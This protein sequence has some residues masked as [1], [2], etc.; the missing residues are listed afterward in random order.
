MEHQNFVP[1]SGKT[2]CMGCMQFYNAE[3]DVCPFCGYQKDTPVKAPWHIKPGTLLVGRYV[4]GRVVGYG[5]FGVTYIAWDTMLKRRIAIKEYLPSEFATRMADE[6]EIMLLDGEKQLS[7]YQKGLDRFLQEGK[8]L[9]QVGDISGIVHMYNCFQANGT[10]YITMEFL[11]GRTLEEYLAEKGHLTEQETLDLMMPVLEA[12]QSVHE[13]G[14]IHRDI[15]P[16]NIFLTADNEGHLHAKLIDFGASRFATTS[17]SK[18]LTVLIRPGYSPEEQYRSN[19]QQ[20]TFTDVYAVAACMYRMVTGQQPPDALER[21]S[22]IEAKKPDLLQEPGRLNPDLSSNFETALLNALNVRVEDRTA[23]ISDFQEELVSFEPVKRRGDSIRRID[24]LRWPLWA[25]IGVPVAGAAALA[26]LVL[27]AVWVFSSPSSSYALPEGMTRVPDFITAS[28][29]EAQGWADESHLLLTS[30]GAE[31]SPNMTADLVLSQD[32]MAGTVVRENTNISVIISCSQETYQMPD[33]RGMAQE[34]ALAALT[35]MGLAVDTQEGS[36]DGLAA[37]AVAGQSTEPGAEIHTGDAVTLTLSAGSGRAG[38]VPKLEGLSYEE[39]LAAAESA[40]VNLVVKARPFTDAYQDGQVMQQ[41]PGAGGSVSA[42]QTVEIQV[43]QQPR[44]FAMPNLLF[45]SQDEALHLL[46]NIGLSADVQEETSDAVMSGLVLSQSTAAGQQVTPGGRVSLSVSKGGTPVNMPDVVGKT[47]DE[48]RQALSTCRLALNVEY[49]Y[50]AGKAEGTVL[51]QDPVS[52]AP[53]ARGSTVS[54]VVCSK[55]GLV[56]VSDVMGKSSADAKTML[57]GQKLKVQLNEVYS[58][59]AAGTVIAQLPNAGSMQ[60][61]GTVIVLTVSKGKQ[62]APTPAPTPTPAPDPTP[63][64]EPD[65]TPTPTP[66][67]EPAPTWSDWMTSLP[68]G[69]TQ[70]SYYIETKTQYSYRTRET[71]TSESSSMPGWTQVSASTHWG[72]YGAWSDWQDGAVYASDSRQVETRVVYGYYYFQCYNCG[73]RMWGWDMTCPKWAGGCGVGYIDRGSW[74]QMW[75]T[76]SWTD[77]NCQEYG[78]TGKYITY[79]FSD[80]RWFQWGNGDGG[81]KTQY[82]YRDRTQVTVYT[83]ERWTSWTGY[84]DTYRAAD[85]NTQVR[86]RTL[87]RYKK[88]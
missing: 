35:C 3:F 13:K 73:A 85:T 69:V 21:R 6:Q 16:D 56:A 19:G 23:S 88:R 59:S 64:P 62:P 10:A 32:T 44:S 38:T 78:G 14:I 20:G 81:P 52:G 84:S 9:A 50:D 45:K 29:D 68:A 83:Y 34:E 8:R 37:G 57:E 70:S 22:R 75:S 67:P 2:Q 66:T 39:A 36:Y 17:H 79:A 7:Q 42:G 80:G 54:I 86:T 49:G 18:S 76:L 63:T 82:R 26:L 53:V 48:A 41:S 31:Y 5:G 4:I 55:A 43:A 51:S 77:A 1:G 30:S 87:Y 47:E 74:A 60:P 25:K 61:E 58:D 71:T 40:G 72:D 12:L 28:L 33:V 46:Q 24:F 11:D 65:P 15:S 27:A